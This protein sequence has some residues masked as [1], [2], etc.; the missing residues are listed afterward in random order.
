MTHELE[1]AKRGGRGELR[2]GERRGHRLGIAGDE[3]GFD[4]HDVPLDGEGAQQE[5]GEPAR[6]LGLGLGPP[7]LGDIARDPGERQRRGRHDLVHARRRREQAGEVAHGQLDA[8]EDLGQRH[9]LAQLGQSAERLHAPDHGVER[10]AVAGGGTEGAGRAIQRAGDERALARHERPD[11]AVE[12]APLIAARQGVAGATGQRLEAQAQ[13]HAAG[14][15]G[16]GPLAYPAHQQAE[17]LDGLRHLLAGG[18]VPRAPPVA[19][20]ARHAFE[21]GGGPGDR[22]LAR[23]EGRAAQHA[24]GPE[25]LLGGRAVRARGQGLEPVEAL[26]RLE[27]EEVGGSQGIGHGSVSVSAPRVPHQVEHL[28]HRGPHADHDARGSRCCGRC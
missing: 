21:S 24:R 1:R 7:L 5:L 10:L 15:V 3:Q 17:L 4:R 22:L 2:L 12:L 9:E 6:L 27:G 28:L 8:V 11:A 18:G 19:V 14:G 26:A 23:H 16:L 13:A 25:E 20:G